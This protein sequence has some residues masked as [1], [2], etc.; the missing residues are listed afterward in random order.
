MINESTWH[1][2]TNEQKCFVWS[3][4]LE[5]IQLHHTNDNPSYVIP[6]SIFY[7]ILKE[8]RN[9]ASSN[10]NVVTAGTN[11]TNPTA[12]SVGAWV[13]T[14]K[15]SISTGYLTPRHL[16]F[17]GPILGRMGFITRKMNGNSIQWLFN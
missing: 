10:S 17:I 8:A 7:A 1:K 11:Q 5:G 16:S 14:Q 6:W 13:L 4:T 15:F 9:I 3:A 2:D 12:G